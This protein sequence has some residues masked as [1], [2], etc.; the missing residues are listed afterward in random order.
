MTIFYG[1]Q[2][3]VLNDF[4][5]DKANEV[6]LLASQEASHNKAAKS[7]VDSNVSVPPSPN[8]VPNFGSKV[9]HDSA[10]PAPRPIVCGKFLVIDI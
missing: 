3:I 4:P 10:Q 7:P 6:M 1:G 2:V 5:A 9:T 8:V